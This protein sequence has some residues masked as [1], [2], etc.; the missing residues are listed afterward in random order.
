[1]AITS[2]KILLF[3]GSEERFFKKISLC[4][5]GVPDWLFL[6]GIVEVPNPLRR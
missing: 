1:M 6:L 4:E 5:I 3:F 2:S